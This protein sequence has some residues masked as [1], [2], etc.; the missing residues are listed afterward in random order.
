MAIS[1]DLVFPIDGSRAD[2]YI[3]NRI[4]LFI[5]Q[6]EGDGY[7]M[8]WDEFAAMWIIRNQYNGFDL[9]LQVIK[10]SS[11]LSVLLVKKKKKNGHTGSF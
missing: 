3:F 7:P 11:G 8:R 1:N 4:T 9:Y 6:V 10:G 5:R 2:L